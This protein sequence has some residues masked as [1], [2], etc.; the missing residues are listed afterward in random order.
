MLGGGDMQFLKRELKGSF[1][2][3]ASVLLP[4]I[5]FIILGILYMICGLR[6]RALMQTYTFR[7]AEAALTEHQFE[8][9]DAPA[10]EEQ[11]LREAVIM[12]ETDGPFQT[13]ASFSLMSIYRSLKSFY[14]ASAETTGRMQIPDAGIAEFLGSEWDTDYKVTVTGV[15]Y[16]AD[17]FKYKMIRK[18]RQ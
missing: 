5:T 18:G 2:V 15:D 13:A 9:M 10:R 3:E 16:P 7:A 1:T 14:A 17:W 11:S 8:G 4:L 12:S 6:D